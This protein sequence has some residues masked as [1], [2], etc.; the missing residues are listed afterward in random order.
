MGFPS[1]FFWG[2]QAEG[3][4]QAGGGHMD[5]FSGLPHPSHPLVLGTLT[6]GPHPHSH[7]RSQ[8]PAGEASRFSGSPE[9]RPTTKGGHTCAPTQK[10]PPGA[11][12][13]SQ[14]SLRPARPGARA[15]GKEPVVLR[16]TTITLPGG[17]CLFS[18]QPCRDSAGGTLGTRS[19]SPPVLTWGLLSLCRPRCFHGALWEMVG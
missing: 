17:A 9:T 12:P 11:L 6:H 3:C 15:S 4:V 10:F 13:R 7:P 19:C 5:M 14:A 8:A 16:P 18:H 1:A 2:V